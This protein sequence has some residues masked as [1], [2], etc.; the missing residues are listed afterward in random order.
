[1]FEDKNKDPYAPQTFPVLYDNDANLDKSFKSIIEDEAVIRAED[2]KNEALSTLQANSMQLKVAEIVYERT[3]SVPVVTNRFVPSSSV[4]KT[5]VTSV[6]PLKAYYQPIAPTPIPIPSMRSK[7]IKD[8][9]ITSDAVGFK[10]YG[11]SMTLPYSTKEN[12]YIIPPVKPPKEKVPDFTI[13][14]SK[15]EPIKLFAHPSG[16]KIKI[17]VVIII[18]L[19]SIALIA[20]IM[21][22]FYEALKNKNMPFK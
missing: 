7:K 15:P 10:H 1:M 5:K 21:W 16:F 22:V 8:R 20:V 4:A 19:I 14:P 2:Q 12:I 17:A 18:A 13:P 11:G 6:D 3:K 9:Q